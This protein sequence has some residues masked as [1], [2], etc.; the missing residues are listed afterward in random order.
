MNLVKKSVLWLMTGSLPVFI[1]ACY[2]MPHDE[3]TKYAR[4]HVR[5]AL[6]EGIKGI[7]VSC[8]SQTDGAMDDTYT[9]GDD[10]YYE[11]HYHDDAPCATIKFEDVDGEKFGGEFVTKEIPFVEGEEPTVELAPAE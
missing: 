6:G 11:V 2:G 1:A 10:G 5:T 8:M 7:L 4:G 3:N 9:M